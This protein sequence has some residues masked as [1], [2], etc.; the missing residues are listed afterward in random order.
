MYVREHITKAYS[1]QLGILS[2]CNSKHIALSTIRYQFIQPF[3]LPNLQYSTS[4]G[5]IAFWDRVHLF[6]EGEIV[7]YCDGRKFK[8]IKNFP[9]EDIVLIKNKKKEFYCP[10]NYVSIADRVYNIL[11][12]QF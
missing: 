6:K 11:T 2:V 9:N 5:N 4:Q 8:I 7:S 10:Y 3:G 1:E 12:K